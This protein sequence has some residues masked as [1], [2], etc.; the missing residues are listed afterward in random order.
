MILKV[1]LMVK[2]NVC[3]SVVMVLDLTISSVMMEIKM[4]VMDVLANVLSK[5]IIFARE[6]DSNLMFAKIK[7]LFK[8]QL[9]A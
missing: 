5:N 6:M 4:M 2:I 9:I 8:F 3:K 1:I 7:N